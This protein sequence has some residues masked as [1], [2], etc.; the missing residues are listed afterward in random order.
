MPKKAFQVRLS[1]GERA[2]LQAMSVAWQ[3]DGACAYPCVYSAESRSRRR[4][5]W[6]DRCHDP[7]G[8]GCRHL[9]GGTYSAGGGATRIG[10]CVVAEVARTGLLC[11]GPWMAP[12]RPIWLR[13][14]AAPRP[15]EQADGVCACWPTAWSSWATRRLFRMKPS[16]APFKKTNLSPGDRRNGAFRP[17]PMRSSSPPWKTCWRSIRGRMATTCGSAAWTRPAR[18]CWTIRTRRS[19]AAGSVRTIGLRVRPP[20]GRQ[21]L[22]VFRA[23]A[24]PALHG[25]D[26]AA[27]QAGLGPLRPQL[28][29]VPFPSVE[30]IG[31]V[32]ITSTSMIRRRCTKP[33]HPPKPSAWMAR[34]FITPPSMAVGS[35]WPRSKSSVLGGQCLDDRRIPDRT[36]L[37]H[38]VAAWE[39]R[40]NRQGHRHLRFTMADARIKLKRLYPSI[41]A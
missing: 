37:A 14:P 17:R 41:Q 2:R 21:P 13:W 26:R 19:R 30:R 20:R 31:L 28:V 4:W 12:A 34:D 8:T 25:G 10:C 29:D 1:E 11:G 22:S 33:S 40:R 23:I 3:Y 18:N 27:H 6:L 32:R 5:A 7:R 36:T 16:V 15:R 24:R 9:D 35:T 39:Q 38:E